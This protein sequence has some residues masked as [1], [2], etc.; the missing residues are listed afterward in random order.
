[1]LIGLIKT[2]RPK[3]WIKNGF[4][5]VGLIFDRQLLNQAAFSKTLIG[6]GLFSLL[7]AAIYIIN[8]LIDIEADRKHP[9]KSKRPLASGALSAG[10]AMTAT[11]IILV[12][13]FPLAFWL[14]PVFAAIAAGYFVGNLAYSSWLKHIPLIDVLVLAG[15][16]VLRVAAGVSLIEVERF[17]PWLY[18]FTIFLALYLGIGKRRAELVLMAER[19]NDHRRVL[20]G[21]TISF[22]DQLITIVLTLTIITYSLYTFIAPNLPPNNVMMLT[23][24]FVLYGIFRYLYLVHVEDRGDAPEEI[25]FSDRPLQASIILWGL[26]ILLI[27]YFAS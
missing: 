21:Y 23:I 6:F 25:L 13:V 8:D 19:A 26:S 15:F 9:K 12:L 4:L 22:L 2:M 7:A 14:S 16:Y 5:F 10:I 11:V 17:S 24:P 1:M 18:V 27:F 3:Q 20:D